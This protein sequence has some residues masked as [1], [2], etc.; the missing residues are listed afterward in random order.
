M[1][2]NDSSKGNQS[3]GGGF[4]DRKDLYSNKA[5]YDSMKTSFFLLTA[6]VF[7]KCGTMVLIVIMKNNTRYS[8]YPYL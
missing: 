4:E 8:T 5:F 7:Y 1:S 6:R 2:P 3:A